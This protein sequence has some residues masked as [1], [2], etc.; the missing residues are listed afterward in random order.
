MPYCTPALPLTFLN[1]TIHDCPTLLLSIFHDIYRFPSVKSSASKLA[2]AS[3]F[4]SHSD[5]WKSRWQSSSTTS[6][7]VDSLCLI[8]FR[9]YKPCNDWPFKGMPIISY[10]HQCISFSPISLMGFLAW[11]GQRLNTVIPR[12]LVWFPPSLITVDKKESFLP[13]N[14]TT[15]IA[16]VPARGCSGIIE[17]ASLSRKIP[18]DLSRTQ[19][20]WFFHFLAFFFFLPVT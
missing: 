1:L 9:K 14:W 5:Y 20:H 15:P 2:R 10:W 19:F 18:R 12:R 11:Y 3:Y 13:L 6:S 17:T 4:T 7:T 16:V 8:H